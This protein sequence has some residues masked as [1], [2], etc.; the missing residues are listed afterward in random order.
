[1]SKVAEYYDDYTQR[2]AKI[3]INDRHRSIQRWLEKFGL[4]RTDSVLEIG[5]GIGTQTKLLAQYLSPSAKIVANDI[6]PKSVEIGK[7]TLAAHRNIEWIAADIITHPL[8]GQFDVV[9]LPDVIEHIPIEQHSALFQKISQ[10]LKPTGFVLIHIPNPNFLQ[11]CRETRPETLQVID[12]PIFTNLLTQNVYPHGLFI[13]FLETYT[14]FKENN[15]YQ[16]VVLKKVRR[17]LTYF[18]REYS[19]REKVQRKVRKFF[20][21][22]FG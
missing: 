2:Q 3:G 4:R 15:D 5:C 22:I 17:D 14:I 1:M 12:Q 13:H 16:V 21:K 11:W 6:S 9:L 20:K 8:D 10:V 7:K 19:F 18:E